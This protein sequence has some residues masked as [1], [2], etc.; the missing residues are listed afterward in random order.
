MRILTTMAATA[1]LVVSLALTSVV[2]AAAQS[3]FRGGSDLDGTIFEWIPSKQG[4][5]VLVGDRRS[6]HPIITRSSKG[7]RYVFGADNG[8]RCPDHVNLSGQVKVYRIAQMRISRLMI[9]LLDTNN[10]WWGMWKESWSS[11]KVYKKK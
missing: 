10:D 1:G 3:T 7:V 8:Q 4:P 2:P 9:E 5:C 6:K 11:Y